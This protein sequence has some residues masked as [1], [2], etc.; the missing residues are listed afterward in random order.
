[1]ERTS[2]SGKCK[3]PGFEE[4]LLGARRFHPGLGERVR[5]AAA[6]NERADLARL[7]AQL[8]GDGTR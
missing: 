5:A 7:V 4:E 6:A 8:F 3:Q 2:M 1:M